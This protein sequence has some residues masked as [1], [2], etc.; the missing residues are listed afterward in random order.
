MGRTTTL[1]TAA[2]R[3]P[4]H[5]VG[6]TFLRS[7]AESVQSLLR[8]L[9][10]LA[11][12]SVPV[13]V[14]GE[15]GVG[16]EVLARAIHDQSDRRSEPFVA[17][18]CAALQRDLLEAELFGHARGAFTGAHRERVGKFEAAGAGTLLLDEVGELPLDLQAKL[19]RA[20][21]E[22]SFEPLGSNQ[23]IPFEARLLSATSRNLRD[24]IATSNFRLDLY[25][26]LAV[27]TLEVPPLRRRLEDLPRICAAL[28]ERH[29]E[30]ESVPLIALAPELYDAMRRYEWPGN[31]RELENV[32]I[33]SAV[34]S[35]GPIID[36][37][38]LPTVPMR[39]PDLTA[40]AMLLPLPTTA[41]Q[42]T[43][44]DECERLIID[45]ALQATD[46]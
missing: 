2:I 18:N 38:M 13:L 37:L 40:A 22:R 25:Y 43:P 16:K 30:R 3:P 10:R 14:T 17:V 21:Q 32:L 7:R 12:M 27:V 39:Q 6:E 1:R 8:Q 20:V 28:L 44:L 24:A 42:I 15:S 19:L 9:G 11:S 34:A 46:W 26:R 29:C 33:A 23:T 41:D 31:I 5:S 36:Q 45:A 35:D 4:E